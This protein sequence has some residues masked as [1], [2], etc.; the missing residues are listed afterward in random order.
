M[1]EHIGQPV[2][3]IAATSFSAIQGI[4]W[5]LKPGEGPPA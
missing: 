4:V 3:A 5:K 1:V 2:V